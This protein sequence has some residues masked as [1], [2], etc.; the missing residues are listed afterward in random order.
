MN[1]KILIVDD[2]NIF[3]EMLKENL[4]EFS[5][6][7]MNFIIDGTSSSDS[8]LNQIKI[9]KYDLLILDFLIDKSNGKQLVEKIRNFDN[10]IKI[11]ILTGHSEYINTI[12]AVKDMDIQL[13][14]EKSPF[15][16]ENII[17]KI[18]NIINL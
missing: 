12:G 7:S 9:K 11:I 3:V 16:R 2:D 18:I 8:A 10:S 17:M 15:V 13:V 6:D 1:K 5:N 4:E 14:I